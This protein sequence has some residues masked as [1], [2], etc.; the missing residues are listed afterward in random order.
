M[1]GLFA[2]IQISEEAHERRQNP[3]R[4]RSVKSLNGPAE[5]FGHS[6]GIY[7]KL[8]NGAAR[9]NCARASPTHNSVARH[10][11]DRGFAKGQ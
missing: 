10:C 4:F 7:A 1:H 5:L 2:E 9:H 8:A 11:A 6:G 3:A